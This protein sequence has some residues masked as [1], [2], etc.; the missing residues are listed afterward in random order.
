MPQRTLLGV[1]AGRSTPLCRTPANKAQ[2]THV[3]TKAE[4]HCTRVRALGAGSGTRTHARMHT[5]TYVHMPRRQRCVLTGLNEGLSRRSFTG[6]NFPR[7]SSWVTCS[8]Q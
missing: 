6:S 4:H 3:K 5:R 2:R 1:W 8:G 7:I